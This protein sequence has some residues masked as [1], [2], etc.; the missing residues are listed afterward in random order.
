[1]PVS[2]PI[3]SRETSLSAAN[4]GSLGEPLLPPDAPDNSDALISIDTH[5]IADI[6]RRRFPA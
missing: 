3:T 4:G 1:M 5:L 2:G 6:W